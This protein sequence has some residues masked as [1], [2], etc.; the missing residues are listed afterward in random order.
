MD[1]AETYDRIAEDWHNDH[2]MDDWWQEGTD[3]FIQRLTP[4]SRVLDVGCGSGIK[5]KYL[6]DHG[7]CVTGVDIS[8]K[9]LDI[10]R[11]VAP[12]ATFV[13]GSM[14]DIKSVAGTFEAVFAQASLL[15]IPRKDAPEVVREMASKVEPSGLLYLAVKEQREGNPSEEVRKEDDYGY[16]YERFFSYF[17]LEDLISYLTDAGLSVVWQDRKQSGGTVWLQIIGQ[18]PNK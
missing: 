11:T 7:L 4:G 10:A 18:K 2:G 8:R 13:L 5:S 17:T 1:L 3:V 14:Q 16:E 12:D 6:T 9:F 15:H